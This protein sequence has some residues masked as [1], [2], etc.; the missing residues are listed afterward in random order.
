MLKI[1][2]SFCVIWLFVV[3]LSNNIS[4]LSFEEEFWLSV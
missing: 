3:I 2:F 4:E 1:I